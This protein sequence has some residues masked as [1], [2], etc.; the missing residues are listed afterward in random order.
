VFLRHLEKSGWPPAGRLANADVFDK[1]VAPLLQESGR[2]VA[3]LLIDALRYELGVEL[4]KQ[5]PEG[6]QIE[7]QPAF[8]QLPSVTPV[9]MASLLPG[10]GQHLKLLKKDDGMAAVLGDLSLTTVAQRMDILRKRYG[11]RFAETTL[12]EFVKRKVDLP[13][14]VE[15]LVIRSNEM[16]S[17]FESNPEAAPSLISRTFQQIRGAIHKLRG[18]GF[19]DAIILT[20]HGFYMNTAAGA[21]DVCA[22]PPG[23][24]LTIHERLLL[25]DGAG[26]AANVVLPTE[27]LGIRGDFS[28]AAIPRAMVAYKAGQWYFHGGASLQEA[29]VPV[30]AVRFR[31]IE[32]QVGRQPNVTLHYKR[33]AKRITTRLPVLEIEVG[34]GDLF[35]M[36]AAFDVL[37]EAQDR[38]GNVV[39]E[40]K[41]GG[42]VNPATKTV[43][44]NP[45]DIIQVTLQMALEFEGKFTVKALDPTTLTTFSK[46]DLETYYTV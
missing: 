33:G 24:W 44:V 15:L 17:N 16:D 20:D 38:Q 9:G 23:K 42:P 40:V 21:G 32:A 29:L 25:G 13:G 35:S 41:P 26:N 19:Q 11:Q 31:P 27:L 22:K 46:I 2:R 7:L 30:I 14:T 12:L 39:G 34:S 10:A 18:L 36:S 4:H 3:L 6:S 28:Q 37:I 43:T 45:G 8:V 1:L 5:L